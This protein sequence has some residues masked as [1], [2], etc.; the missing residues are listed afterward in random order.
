[1]NVYMVN[2]KPW[3]ISAT[4]CSA[5]TSDSEAYAQTK[6]AKG[7]DSSVAHHED[8]HAPCLRPGRPKATDASRQHKL[9]IALLKACRQ[10]YAEA[11]GYL[12]ADN[13]FSFRT[14]EDLDLFISIA[15]NPVQRLWI[16]SMRLHCET[17]RYNR[18][19]FSAVTEGMV[20]TLEGLKFFGLTVADYYKPYGIPAL[21]KAPTGRL[22]SVEVII[23]PKPT[24][25]KG[26]VVD[27]HKNRH[28]AEE[29]ERRLRGVHEI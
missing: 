10:I 7:E 20:K 17:T 21:P 2:G 11:V 14:S 26:T 3:G 9:P 12:Y 8:R 4:V 28:H 25:A 29:F 22:E 16:R 15:L 5:T 6:L 18:D 1:M 27:A 23:G 24:H 13:N 19:P